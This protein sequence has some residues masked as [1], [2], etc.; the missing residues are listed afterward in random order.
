M[1][2]DPPDLFPLLRAD[3]VVFADAQDY[4]IDDLLRCPVAVRSE[5]GGGC[6]SDTV[7]RSGHRSTK[8]AR[9]LWFLT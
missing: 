7:F 2:Y 3:E 6:V 8:H 4:L 1:V 9:P 5:K